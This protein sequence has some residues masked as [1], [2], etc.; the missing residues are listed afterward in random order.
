[1]TEVLVR[2][3]PDGTIAEI[4]VTGHTG[5]A[6][7][8]ED[9]VCAGVSALV[10][11]AL[12]GLKKV[13]QHPYAGKATSGKMYCKVLPG[14]TPESAMKA[15]AILATTVFGLQDIARDYHH[16]VRVTEGG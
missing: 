3:A 9:I 12:I 2:R 11:T 13:A 7:E 1:M 16:F 8:G 14:G 10:V 15:Q 6:E 5:Y 4:R